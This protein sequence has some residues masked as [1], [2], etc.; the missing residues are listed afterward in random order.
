MSKIE[1]HKNLRNKL[2][3]EID[4]NELSI[5]EF[6]KNYVNELTELPEIDVSIDYILNN[7][8][9]KPQIPQVPKIPVKENLNMKDFFKNIGGKSGL[10]TPECNQ[11]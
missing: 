9:K 11:Q 7:F 1:F 5:K 10:D 4:I 8:V 2:K 3:D 6:I